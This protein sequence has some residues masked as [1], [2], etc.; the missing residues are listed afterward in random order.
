MITIERKQGNY[1]LAYGFGDVYVFSKSGKLGGNIPDPVCDYIFK[2]MPLKAVKML[3]PPMEQWNLNHIRHQD[4]PK[5]MKKII[6]EK[7]D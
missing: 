2:E 7:H 1:I 5:W 4:L 6:L 3:F